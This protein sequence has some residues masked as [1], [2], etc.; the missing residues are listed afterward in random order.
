M[1]KQVQG[2]TLI[3]LVIT[4]IVLLIL[5]GVAINLSLGENG[6]F[7]RAKEAKIKYTEAQLKEEL[8]TELASLLIDAKSQ[9][10]DV[11]IDD[12][13]NKMDEIG[14]VL[15]V[16]DD[17]IE[18]EYKDHNVTI[19]KDGNVTIGNK[20]TGIKPTAE[21]TILTEEEERVEMQVV[22]STEEGE[23]AS[24]EPINGAVLKTE[25]SVS[26]KIYEV[27]N[28]GVY[29]F[30]IKGTNGRTTIA[31]QEVTS[32]VLEMEAESILEGLAKVNTS[33][34]VKM[35]VKGKTSSESEEEE[36]TYRLNIIN[37]T[38]NLV[39]N[40]EE[41]DEKIEEL[42]LEGITIDKTNKIYSFGTTKDIG[43]ASAYAQNTVVLKVDGNLTIN[44]E[45]TA[46]AIGSAYGGPKG[47]IIYCTGTV[48][49]NGTINMSARGAKAVG[50]NVYLLK[51]KNTEGTYEYIPAV[52]A[53]ARAGV[54]RKY[55]T[56]SINGY[57]G[58]NATGRG[59]G[60]GGTGG[61]KENMNYWAWRYAGGGSAGTSYSGGSGGGGILTQGTAGS[62]AT[63]GG[64]G[65]YAY[66]FRGAQGTGG[67]AGNPGGSGSQ[68]GSTGGT[69]TGGLLVICT[70]DFVNSET[71]KLISN[72]SSGGYR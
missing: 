4:I 34:L 35:K 3:A 11:S 6:I 68:G 43:T 1:K 66:S 54:A 56:E 37:K 33:G 71:G 9:G 17:I 67:G 42:K 21:I 24:I 22:A 41:D 61:S 31:K 8:E 15:G 50:E 13:A 5:A 47:L 28:N 48:T 20:L 69:G 65:G 60:A 44:E 23:I 70:K 46:T 58:Y 30:R 49:N 55:G 63:N 51:N 25:N 40:A 19:D 53:A 18:G 38:G 27:T 16:E 52:G 62:G 72:G 64:A 7:N 14:E 32:L 10:R 45:V 59:L 29:K 57:A 39:L 2:I 26:D 36:I 12:I